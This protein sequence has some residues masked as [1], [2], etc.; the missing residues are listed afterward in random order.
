MSLTSRSR[1]RPRPLREAR[2]DDE[3]VSLADAFQILERST[4]FHQFLGEVERERAGVAAGLLAGRADCYETYLEQRGIYTGLSI[5]LGL[6]GEVVEEATQVKVGDS[7]Y[8][9]D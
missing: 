7:A 4:E 3:S 8:D 1:G 2:T 5:V 6:V 9:V